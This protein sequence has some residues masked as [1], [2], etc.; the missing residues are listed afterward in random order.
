MSVDTALLFRLSVLFD[1]FLNF[2]SLISSW[3][4]FIAKILN[5]GIFYWIIHLF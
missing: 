1:L 2:P 5:N 4:A 3:N